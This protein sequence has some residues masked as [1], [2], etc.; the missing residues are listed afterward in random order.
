MKRY[1]V[2]VSLRP[3]AQASEIEVVENEDGSLSQVSRTPLGDEFRPLMAQLYFRIQLDSR[4]LERLD[5]CDSALRHEVDSVT[6]DLGSYL[7]SAEGQEFADQIFPGLFEMLVE[8]HA[9]IRRG[10]AA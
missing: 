1:E 10:G 5:I 7:K 3:E 4:L 6:K 9:L 2:L 8:T